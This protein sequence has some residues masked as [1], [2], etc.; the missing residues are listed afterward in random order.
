MAPAA[1][2]V[3]E[4]GPGKRPPDGGFAF[5]VGRGLSVSA[6]E[7]LALNWSEFLSAIRLAGRLSHPLPGL[8]S[9]P[10]S[11]P[12]IVSNVAGRISSVTGLAPGGREDIV[13]GC[14]GDRPRSGSR[15]L[16][17]SFPGGKGDGGAGD[18]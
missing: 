16:Q 13:Q 2:K 6:L 12:D 14:P 8:S 9:S 7:A 15:L 10:L 5:V 3:N 11:H 4:K 17:S 18:P 1:P